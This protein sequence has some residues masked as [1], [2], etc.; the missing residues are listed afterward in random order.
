MKKTILITS[1]AYL[2]NIGGV[3]NS[4]KYLAQSYKKLGYQ[5]IV[6][7]SDVA[8]N[9][10][11]LPFFEKTDGIS[12]YR[13]NT[14]A[15]ADG[16]TQFFRALR[17]MLN[18][19]KLLKKLNHEHHIILTLSRFHTTTV[20]AKLA[21]LKNVTYLVP[22]VVKNQN[23]NANLVNN[24][25]IAKLKL[26]IS[27]LLHHSI[28]K[29]AFKYCDQVL[30]FSQNMAQQVTEIQTTLTALPIV[31]P[32]VD[33]QR[34]CPIKDKSTLKIKYNIP[35]DKIILLTVGRFVRA[36][37]FDLVIDALKNLPQC[38]LV[39]V[40]D[41]ENFSVSQQQIVKNNVSEQVTLMGSQQDTAPFYQL[42][43]IFVMSSRYEPL[44]QTILEALSCALPIMAFKGENVTTATTEL[45][46]DDEAVYSSK[47]TSNGLEKGIK[48]LVDNHQ[49][50]EN[51]ALNSRKIALERFS[52]STLAQQTL[53]LNN[54]S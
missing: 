33:H 45:L 52:W 2:P 24:S 44:G 47:I 16:I 29:T 3:E 12:I 54:V 49:Y 39:M 53:A 30:V 21:H 18:A 28:Q 26:N 46:N 7:V 22:G 42:S 43:D 51:L 9:G 19:I 38:H 6:V 31:K 35:T 48:K 34:F 5:V 32:G 8:A 41:G 10:E 17:T 40:G 50:R 1:N 13:Y 37:G 23:T 15:K 36:K 4:L 27:R 25:G 14:F 20:L 11:E